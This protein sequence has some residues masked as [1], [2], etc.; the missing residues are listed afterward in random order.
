MYPKALLKT[1]FA[2]FKTC[3]LTT[4]CVRRFCVPGGFPG[5]VPYVGGAAW[6]HSAAGAARSLS[7]FAHARAAIDSQS[8]DARR[9]RP[10]VSIIIAAVTKSK[11][12]FVNG[13]VTPTF[14]INNWRK[15]IK[16]H[17]AFSIAAHCVD[18]IYTIRHC[19]CKVYA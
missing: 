4:W 12:C 10:H 15:I 14:I 18:L 16:T 5:H 1:Q 7:S 17:V 19:S 13:L 11:V 8:A 6:A 3:L 9:R 2:F